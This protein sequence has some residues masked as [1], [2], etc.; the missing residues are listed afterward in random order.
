MTDKL[1]VLNDQFHSEPLVFKE[2]YRTAVH[3]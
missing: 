2:V 3:Q 1:S